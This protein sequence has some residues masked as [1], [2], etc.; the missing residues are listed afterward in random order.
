MTDVA[1]GGH[2]REGAAGVAH[3]RQGMLDESAAN[4]ALLGGR[5]DR[6][7]V[8]LADT[9]ARSDHHADKAEDLRTGR[10]NCAQ[11]LR[12][13]T[14]A[15]DGRRLRAIQSGYTRCPTCLPST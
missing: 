10:G 7:Q 8:D 2:L 14:C 11:D 5:I 1:T 9:F 4:A 12:V 3:L 13:G 15:T 6:N